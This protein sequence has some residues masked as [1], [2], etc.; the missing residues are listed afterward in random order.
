MLLMCLL[1]SGCRKAPPDG[2]SP[3]LNRALKRA[4]QKDIVASEAKDSILCSCDNLTVWLR[5]HKAKDDI[6]I[7]VAGEKVGAVYVVAAGHLL[8]VIPVDL[9]KQPFSPA[10]YRW[11]DG[12]LLVSSYTF[13]PEAYISGRWQ[14]T[15]QVHLIAEGTCQLVF[16]ENFIAAEIGPDNAQIVRTHAVVLEYSDRPAVLRLRSQPRKDSPKEYVFEV[17]SCARWDIGKQEFVAQQP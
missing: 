14:Y 4:G 12:G 11:T 7:S 17:E 15:L 3:E 8:K 6:F 9:L 5:S 16:E 2:L 10:V 1:M 13:G